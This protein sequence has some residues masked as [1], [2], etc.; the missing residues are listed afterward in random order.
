MSV[1]RELVEVFDDCV[2]RINSGASIAD[3][4]SA[5]PQY[6]ALL[7]PLLETSLAAKR[8]LVVN[9]AETLQ[10][11]DRVRA[12]ILAAQRRT[13]REQKRRVIPLRSFAL[14]AAA[15]IL[16]VF[17]ALSLV[18]EA[19]LP[20]DPLYSVKRLT[21]SVRENLIPQTAALF[22]Q[23]RIDEIQRLLTA[24]REAEVAFVGQVE[25][26]EGQTWTVAGLPLQVS[27]DTPG[28][29]LSLTG[30]RVEVRAR[31][32]SDGTLLALEIVEVP[33]DGSNEIELTPVVTATSTDLPTETTAPSVTPTPTTNATVTK[34]ATATPSATSTASPTRTPPA[35]VTPASTST[36]TSSVC[37]PSQPSGWIRYQ[38]QSGDTLSALAAGTGVTIDELI[39]VNCIAN[40]SVLIVGQTLFLPQQPVSEDNTDDGEDNDDDSGSGDDDND[41]DGGGDDND[42]DDSGGDDDDNDDEEDDEDDDNNSGSDDDDDDVN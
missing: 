9:R 26:I 21:E 36:A 42:D 24:G 30:R 3:C 15:S 40:P 41:D 33:D 39:Q 22:E 14:T 18:A 20:G 29:D 10:A 1:N 25:A 17:I 13:E 4:L 2:N 23:R 5:Y 38:V 35:S 19:S 34:T 6:A 16:I 12:Q 28:A 7:R 37:M 8:G 11:K 31:T 32:Q 27:D